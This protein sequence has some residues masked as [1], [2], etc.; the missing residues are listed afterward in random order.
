M[1]P[2]GVMAQKYHLVLQADKCSC[3][4]ILVYS[5]KIIAHI[6]KYF[7]CLPAYGNILP[8]PNFANFNVRNQIIVA[9]L[10]CTECHQKWGSY[11]AHLYH[12]VTSYGAVLI[13]NFSVVFMTMAIIYYKVFCRIRNMI[14]AQGVV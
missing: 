2:F 6:I 14:K 7:R 5:F 8:R 13:A 1:I 11:F 10:K 3:W 12:F 4:Y 9:T